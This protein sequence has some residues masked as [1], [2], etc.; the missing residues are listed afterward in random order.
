MATV[1]INGKEISVEDG[2]L[3]LL[4]DML[5]YFNTEGMG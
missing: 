2:T 3:I 4:Q 1:K 5:V